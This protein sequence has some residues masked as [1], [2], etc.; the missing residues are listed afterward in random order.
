MR[1]SPAQEST[2]ALLRRGEPLVFDAEFVV[3]LRKIAGLSQRDVAA[4]MGISEGTVEKQITKGI[5]FLTAALGEC[6][7]NVQT[8]S[9]REVA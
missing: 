2:L 1:M 4:H 9:E 3:E 7:N 6:G 5:R 8:I